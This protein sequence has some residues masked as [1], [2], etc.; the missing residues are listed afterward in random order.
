MELKGE[1][2]IVTGGDGGF[3]EGIARALV[4][5]GAKVWITGRNREKLESAAERTGAVPVVADVTSGA[6]WDRLFSLVGDDVGIL[7]NNAGAGVRIAP[8]AGQSDAEIA[9]SVNI[10]LTGAIMGCARAAAVMGKWRRGAIVNISSVC[11]L[12]AWPGW[13]VYT[14]AKAGLSKFSHALYT[15]MRPLGVRVF[16]VTPSWGATGFNR[17]AGIEGASEDPSLAAKCIAPGEIGR[18]VA[19]LLET[20]DHL[21]VP[22]VTLQPMIQDIQPM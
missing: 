16:N 9:D 10:N 14:A 15:E 8:L 19:D 4:E 6:D 17:A 2:A 7:V 1:K 18:L 3:G 12:Y 13:S 5:R 11:S 21:A 22:D 20:P